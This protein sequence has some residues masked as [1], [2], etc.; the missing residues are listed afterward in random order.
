MKRQRSCFHFNYLVVFLWSLATPC[1]AF[2]PSRSNSYYSIPVLFGTVEDEQ[3]RRDLLDKASKLR[4]E[5]NDLESTLDSATRRRPGQEARGAPE[6]VYQSI[7]GSTWELSYRFSD[8]PERKEGTETAPRD[9]FAGKLTLCM[10]PDGYTDIVVHEPSGEKKVNILKAWGW[11]VET[12][13]EDEKDYLLFSLDVKVPSSDEEKTRFYFQARQDGADEATGVVLKEGTITIKQDIVE[14]GRS[15]GLWGFF[16]P[17]GILAE[18]RYVGDFIAR[19][20][21]S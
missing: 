2:L 9:F 15:P 21:S 19:P 1:L 10:K 7:P 12:S 17:K 16:S 8:K 4:Q 13:S 6:P 18:F 14:S 20:S 5:A 3:E 11:D